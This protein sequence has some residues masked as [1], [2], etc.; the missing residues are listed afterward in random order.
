MNFSDYL[1]NIVLALI[2]LGV[3]LSLTINDFRNVFKHPS[4][5]I[6]ALAVQVIIVPIIAFIV[7]ELSP[8]NGEM[9]AGL[10]IVSTCASGAASNLV[11]HIFKGRVALAISMTII[12]GLLTLLTVPFTVSL[13]LK[14]FIGTSAEITLPVGETI[15]QIFLISI[16]P[17]VLGIYLRSLNRDFASKIE[18]PL[19]IIMP[20]MLAFVFLIKIFADEEIGGTNISLNEVLLIFPVAF[21]LNAL[22]MSAGFWIMRLLRFDFETQFTIGIEVGLHNTALALMIAGAMINSTDMEKPALVYASFSFFT[23]VFF[24]L[25]VRKMFGRK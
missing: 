6:S 11:T 18:R 21:V 23:A 3:G 9:R 5:L 14:F 22:A 17:A 12:N 13:A 4:A 7:A 8:M 15:F 25:V 1:I 2:M 24:V 16:L 19:K 20:V 10:V